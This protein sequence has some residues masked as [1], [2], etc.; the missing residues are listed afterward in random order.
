MALFSV[1]LLLFNDGRKTYRLEVRKYKNPE[2]QKYSHMPKLM[3][4]GYD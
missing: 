1:M 4:I 2:V 3:M